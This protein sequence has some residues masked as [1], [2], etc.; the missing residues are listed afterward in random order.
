[1]HELGQLSFA[2]DIPIHFL[3]ETG[4]SKVYSA[5]NSNMSSQS[6]LAFFTMDLIQVRHFFCNL[7]HM[8][9]QNLL[10]QLHYWTGIKADEVN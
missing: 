5:C 1:M 7:D 3:A 9:L 2:M 4:N 6:D 8:V 10:M